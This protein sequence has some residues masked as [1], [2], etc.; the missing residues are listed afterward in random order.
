MG[1][2]NG[3]FVGMTLMVVWDNCSDLRNYF[4]EI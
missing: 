2:E 3:K 1:W 4:G